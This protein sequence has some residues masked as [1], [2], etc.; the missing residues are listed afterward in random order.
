MLSSDAPDGG[1]SVR[2][3]RPSQPRSVPGS[4]TIRMLRDRQ[5]GRVATMVVRR[6]RDAIRTTG[7]D[8]P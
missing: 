4:R 8:H 3:L 7:E 1:G 6:N 5:P 2:C